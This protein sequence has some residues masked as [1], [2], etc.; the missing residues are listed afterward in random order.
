MRE[1]EIKA[2]P[3]TFLPQTRPH[4]AWWPHT[5]DKRVASYR[6]RCLQVM[7]GLQERGYKTSLWNP[8]RELPDVLVLSKRFDSK[9]IRTVVEIADENN[10]PWVLDFCDNYFDVD[11][12]DTFWLDRKRSL[13]NAAEN[14]TSV[15]NSSRALSEVTHR[16][17]SLKSS[18]NVIADAV[19]PMV[20]MGLRSMFSS[21]ALI[22]QA[23]LYAAR[24]KSSFPDRRRRL[25]WF[26][27][28]AS[29]HASGGMS[30]ITGLKSTLEK[31]HQKKPIQL[32]IISNDLPL[33]KKL[34]SGWH[35]PV[36][37]LPWSIHTFSW[38]LRQHGTCLIPANLNEFTLC[39]TNN[40]L[41]TAIEHDVLP[42]YDP[43]P[44]YLEFESF[45]PAGVNMRNINKAITC[46]KPDDLI[47]QAKEFAKRK[48]GLQSILNQWESLFN[49][50]FS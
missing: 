42:V 41:L 17:C 40:R 48:Y 23:R 2:Q 9:S 6:L 24:M 26:G 47:S 4:I 13:V 12:N 22:L 19:E 1:A 15:V 43:I 29:P 35:V 38:L 11:I 37:Y 33:F 10:L 16:N 45:M 30:D 28:A 7:N 31:V 49:G 18:I 8:D 36:S 3:M 34:F 46:D 44:S 5:T 27:N 21:P 32:T 50:I 20:P 39:K 14:A 25:V